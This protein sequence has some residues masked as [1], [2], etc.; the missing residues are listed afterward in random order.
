MSPKC[1]STPFPTGSIANA[2]SSPI[3]PSKDLLQQNSNPTKKTPIP[4][5]TTKSSTMSFANTSKNICPLTTLQRNTTTPSNSS[6]TSSNASTAMNTNA[7]K[8]P[9][10]YA[11]P[12][13]P[14][15][16]A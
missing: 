14:S 13:K 5:Q 7:A 10:A 9:Q 3:P 8:A 4:S 6:M 16:S 2:K 11:S 15:P 1:K 12:T